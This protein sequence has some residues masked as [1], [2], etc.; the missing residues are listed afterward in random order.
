MRVVRY[1]LPGLL[2]LGLL[3][4][5]VGWYRSAS[6]GDYQRFDSCSFDGTTLVLSYSYG[7]NQMISPSVDT[8]GPDV[9]VA[10]ESEV[11]EGPT[12]AIALHGEARFVMFGAQTTIR[13]P[14]G[15][16]LNCSPRG[17][18]SR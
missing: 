11:G 14:D 18:G 7:A 3:V 9:V 13:Y 16:A 10:L 4:T 8:R 6:A 15:Q 2:A 1:I 12:P 5:S 17:S